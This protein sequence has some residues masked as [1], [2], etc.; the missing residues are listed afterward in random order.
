MT[1]VD[2]AAFSN[3]AL[4][5]IKSDVALPALDFTAGGF[6]VFSS[7]DVSGYCTIA[8]GACPADSTAYY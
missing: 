6:L 8:G 7:A 3:V 4:A 5:S 1:R 2:G